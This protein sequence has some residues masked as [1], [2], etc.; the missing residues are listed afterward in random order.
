MMIASFRTA[1]P[2]DGMRFAR[3]RTYPW[4]HKRIWVNQAVYN[5]ISLPSAAL[6]LFLPPAFGG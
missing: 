3:F 4:H 2:L 6:R 5:R 1:L